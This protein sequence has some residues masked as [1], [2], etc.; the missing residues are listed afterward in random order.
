MKDITRTLWQVTTNGDQYDVGTSIEKS[1]S[2]YIVEGTGECKDWEIAVK[3]I[4]STEKQA[5]QKEKWLV[6]VVKKSL[7]KRKIPW[8]YKIL[9]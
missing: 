8:Y 5:T 7:E 3:T 1:G 6:R 4:A 9:L 2:K